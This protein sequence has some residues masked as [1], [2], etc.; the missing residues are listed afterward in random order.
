MRLLVVEDQVKMASFIS[1]GLTQAG[2][3]VDIAESSGAAESLVSGNPYD[4]VILDVMLPDRSGIDTARHLRADGYRGPIL[5]LTALSGTRDRIHGLDAGADDYLSKP[6]DFGELEARL[7]ALLRRATESQSGVN[8]V[9]RIRDLEIN[10]ITRVV[11]RG[12]EKIQLTP[13]EFSL[14]E[15]LMRHAGRPVSRVAIAE[16]VW[17]MHYDNESNIIDVYVN[18]LRKK[19]DK[20]NPV[21][22]IRTVVGVGYLLSNE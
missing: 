1:K 13:K 11:T 21:K 8:S 20:D 19:V 15:F 7:R 17:D 2:Y 9:L 22:L 10:L 16:S 12:T 18:T 6:F 4:V 3:T 14:L 5:M